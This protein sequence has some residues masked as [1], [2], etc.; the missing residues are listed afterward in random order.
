MDKIWLKSYS[1]G[2]PA[3]V[4]TQTYASVSAFFQACCAKYGD[5]P[6]Y[7]SLGT[8]LSYKQLY[9]RA[10]SFAA[11]L[12]QELCLPR[13][14]RVALMLPNV[15]QYPIAM[16]GSLLAGMVVVNVNPLYTVDELV[17][18]LQDSGTALIVVLANMACT[19]ERA[20]RSVTMPHVMVTQ[21]GDAYPWVK[22]QLVNASVKHIKKMVPAYHLP[23][24][25]CWRKALRQGRRKQL[26]AV[27]TQ[28]DDLAFLQYTGGTTG[29]AKG[30]MLTHANIVAN[31]LQIR[32]W[33][34]PLIQ[35][36]GET[37]LTPLPLYHIFS[38][39]C[40]CLSFFSFGARNV[41]VINPRDMR[42]II[43][44]FKRYPITAMTAVNTLYNALLH[45]PQFTRAHVAHV[46]LAVGGGMPVQ[47][48]V[49]D[50]W[51][52][53]TGVPIVEGY[54]LTEAS[55]VVTVNLPSQ[56][57]FN[58]SIGL[59]LP[60]TEISIRRDNGEEVAQG[61]TGELCVR[62]PQVMR[63]YWQQPDETATVLSAD[64]WLTTGDIA[65]M[66]DKGFIYLVDRK[67][68]MILISG[69][70]VY[71]TEVEN[72]IASC[73]GVLEVAIIGVTDAEG[74]E[75]VKAFIVKKQADL[76]SADV[77]AYCEQHL[78]RYKLPKIIVFTDAL[79]KSNIGKILRRALRDVPTKN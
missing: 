7:S 30:A 35:E 61:E 44:E 75:Q 42:S 73:P 58:A 53:R 4:D 48:A 37:V 49:A 27:D 10:Q 16:F 2:V 77:L 15:L 62:G 65:T 52:A 33:F 13:G 9:S 6:A 18:Q 66:D 34:K 40:N 68:D 23:Q 14:S 21:L 26:Q 71:P 38:L 36:S 8:E 57:C 79:P 20:L 63:G 60:S 12:Q 72:V 47:K 25:I 43:T 70:N 51:H 29:I 69:F 22:S 19:V 59:P 11:Y 24:A 3:T 50:A 1:E 32:S 56:P 55:P 31:V 76:T 46:K 74:N 17:H 41:L 5:A 67:K 39:T 78:T 64:G 28:A 45:T 54:G